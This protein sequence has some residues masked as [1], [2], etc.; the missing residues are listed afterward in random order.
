VLRNQDLAELANFIDWAP[1]F[2]TW[3]LAG[4]FPDILKDEVVGAKPRACSPMAN[5]C[6]SA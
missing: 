2:Q 4:R 5:A 1:F 6:S 3:D